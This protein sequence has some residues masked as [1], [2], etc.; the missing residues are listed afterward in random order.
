MKRNVL[1]EDIERP[2]T[3]RPDLV[4]MAVEAVKKSPEQGSR[5]A[6]K[7]VTGKTLGVNDFFEEQ[8]RVDGA[9]CEHTET[10]KYEWLLKLKGHGKSRLHSPLV[11]GICV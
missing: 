11:G 7:V 10:A 9:I 6:I 4:R 3:Y 1:G 8:G 2:C 5:R